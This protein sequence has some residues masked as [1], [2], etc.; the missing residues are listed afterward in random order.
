MLCP[1]P[2]IKVS[3]AAKELQP[4]QT[5]LMLADDPGSKADMIAWAKQ[6]GNE[7]LGVE[8]EGKTFKFYIRKKK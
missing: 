1:V 2:I 5:L 8:E 3:K 6:T 4:G 7:L